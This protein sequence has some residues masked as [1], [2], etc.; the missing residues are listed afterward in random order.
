MYQRIKEKLHETGELMILTDSGEEKEL[1]LHNVEFL[2]EPMAKVEGGEGTHWI[3]LN[4][5]EQYWI[6]QEF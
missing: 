2:D 4:K 1:H 3:N 5:V 6:H